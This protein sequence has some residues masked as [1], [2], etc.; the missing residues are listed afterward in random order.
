MVDKHS[1]SDTFVT[2]CLITSKRVIVG[3]D[4]RFVI[5]TA[6]VDPKAMPIRIVR[7]MPPYPH[8]T[9]WQETFVFHQELWVLAFKRPSVSI[10]TPS[11]TGASLTISSIV[12]LP[13]LCHVSLCTLS[14]GAIVVPWICGRERLLLLEGWDDS[15]EAAMLRERITDARSLSRR[16]Y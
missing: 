11:T 12:P 3:T 6:S 4:L 14:D 5:V 16:I 8:I 10:A 13:G 9:L 15:D 7:T 2:I 1:S